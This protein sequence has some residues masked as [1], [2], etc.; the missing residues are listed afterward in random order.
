MLKL[1]FDDY[2]DFRALWKN[3]GV[4]TPPGEQSLP[5]PV[6]LE[7]V[8]NSLPTGHKSDIQLDDSVNSTDQ[9]VWIPE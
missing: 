1:K 4:Y 7:G 5:D 6:S 3:G 9:S 8:L 2:T